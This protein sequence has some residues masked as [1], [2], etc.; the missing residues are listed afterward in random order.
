MKFEEVLSLTKQAV[1]QTM[2]DDYM[3]QS[4]LLEGTDSFKIADVGTDIID[5]EA[6]VE[7]FTKS[8]ISLVAKTVLTSKSYNRRIKSLYVDNFEWGGYIQRVYFDLAD[9]ITDEMFNLVNGTSYATQEHKF[10]QPKTSAKL[11]GEAKNICVPIS[12]TRE[13]LKES[14]MSWDSL[15]A[16]LTGIRTMVQ[17]TI[18]LVLY[19]YEKM[20]VSCGIAESVSTNALNNAIHLITDAKAEGVVPSTVTDYASIIA[21]GSDKHKAFLIWVCKKIATV[22]SNMREMSKAYNN[23]NIPTFCESELLLISQFAK[24]IRFD[25]E[26]NTFNSEKLGFGDYEEITAW[27]AINASGADNFDFD[28]VTSVHIG[29][30]SNNKLGIGTE[31]FETSGVIG[32][33]FD[34]MAM[35]LTLEKIKMTSSYTACADFWNEFTHILVNYILDTNFNIVAFVLD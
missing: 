18:N 27:Q 6:T 13:T 19:S 34:R 9:V 29:A 7:K 11:F 26:S 2:G 8:L 12:I 23:G 16:Y 22:R 20:L 32:L 33:A 10:Y 25:A 31:E 28:T 5:S 15:N 17:N 24:D 21:L 1:A 35:G 4:G 14:F 3:S 30:D